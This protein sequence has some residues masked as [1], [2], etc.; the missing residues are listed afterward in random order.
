M[1]GHWKAEIN[2]SWALT[3]WTGWSRRLVELRM[4]ARVRRRALGRL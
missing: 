4:C 2:C 3:H 1:T